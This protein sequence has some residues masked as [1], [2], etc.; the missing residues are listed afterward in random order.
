MIESIQSIR[1]STERVD[2]RENAVK[3]L[4][5]MK[6]IERKRALEMRSTRIDSRTVV[7]STRQAKYLKNDFQKGIAPEP[8]AKYLKRPTRIGKTITR[9]LS[10][11]EDLFEKQQTATWDEINRHLEQKHGLD[12]YGK[13]SNLINGALKKGVLIRDGNSY[14]SIYTLNADKIR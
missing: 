7:C 5:K 3:A 9:Y 14:N 8:C 2:E 4:E 6:E 10:H 1:Y 11:L 13:R 12:S